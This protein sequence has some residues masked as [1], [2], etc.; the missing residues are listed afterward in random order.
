MKEAWVYKMRKHGKPK[1]HGKRAFNA[2][3]VER[4]AFFSRHDRDVAMGGKKEKRTCHANSRT[5]YTAGRSYDVTSAQRW[6]K[7]THS[8]LK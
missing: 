1:Q 8:L 2:Q 7:Y 6:Q 4:L 5:D 3:D